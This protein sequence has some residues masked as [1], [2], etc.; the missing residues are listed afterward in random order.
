MFK[1]ILPGAACL[2]AFV[3]LPIGAHGEETAPKAASAQPVD[4]KPVEATDAG[5]FSAKRT[6][7]KAGS[8]KATPVTTENSKP[9]A[10]KTT[11]NP[12]ETLPSKEPPAA[13]TS[14]KSPT[15]SPAESKPPPKAFAVSP[16][17]AAEQSKA[18]SVQQGTESKK[19][20]LTYEQERVLKEQLR[21]QKKTQE[22]LAKERKIINRTPETD[23]LKNPTL[24]K[25]GSF[26]R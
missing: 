22:Q 17:E 5:T 19:L 26:T 13:R 23:S 24:K 12:D 6:A 7:P 9:I 8:K 21:Q 15:T 16:E 14:S 20:K 11:S 1:S 18:V 4:S 10:P 3:L 25:R 2:A